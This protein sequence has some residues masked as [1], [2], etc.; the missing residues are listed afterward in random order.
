M[1]SLR[2]ILF[3]GLGCC[4]L[5]LPAVGQPLPKHRALDAY[6]VTSPGLAVTALTGPANG[7]NISSTTG[8]I[9]DQV[10]TA[11]TTASGTSQL[12]IGGNSPYQCAAIAPGTSVS[13]NCSGGGTCSWQGDR[14]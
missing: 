12:Q 10:G 3:V 11:G 7:C 9:I 13:V 8:L 1:T 5:A 4:A 2:A 6:A 14:W